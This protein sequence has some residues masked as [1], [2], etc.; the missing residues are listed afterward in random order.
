MVIAVVVL[1]GIG[2]LVL[3]ADSCGTWGNIHLVIDGRTG[4]RYYLVYDKNLGGKVWRASIKFGEE[5][6][7]NAH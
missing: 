1:T 2:A 3:R 7:S 6:C 4:E 5:W